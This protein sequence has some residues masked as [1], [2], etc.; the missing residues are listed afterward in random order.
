[1]QVAGDV[2]YTTLTEG[3]T[4]C[5]LLGV[6]GEVWYTALTEDLTSC[7]DWGRGCVS[8]DGSPGHRVKGS[9]CYTGDSG[10]SSRSRASLCAQ[11][12]IQAP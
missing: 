1:M 7:P 3:L 10:M 8:T 2:W 12:R 6:T 11:G 4:S 5:N 9:T